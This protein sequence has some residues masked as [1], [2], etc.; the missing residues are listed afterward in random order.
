MTLGERIRELR[1]ENDMTL[2]AVAKHIGVG[3]A[4][5]L[6]YENGMITNVPSDKIELIAKLFNVSP[7]YLMGWTDERNRD[8]ENDAIIIKDLDRMAQMLRY[9]PPEDYE[10]VIKAFNRARDKMRAKGID[11]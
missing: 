5:V 10:Y 8:D 3:R 6:K 7:E 1:K 2:D 4:T 9:M 11:I